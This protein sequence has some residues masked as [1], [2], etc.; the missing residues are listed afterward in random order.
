MGAIA[1]TSTSRPGNL[2]D[3]FLDTSDIKISLDISKNLSL[4]FQI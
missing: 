3:V 1:I 4:L 2:A